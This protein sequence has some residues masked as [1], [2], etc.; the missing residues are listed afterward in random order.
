[1]GI[2]LGQ[3]AAMEIDSLLETVRAKVICNQ[4]GGESD[5]SVAWLK[6]HDSYDCPICGD[7]TD[8]T[9]QEWKAR[10]QAYIDA[11]TAFD[12]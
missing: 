2:F 4:C 12:E 8:L 7:S 3:T 1:M 5:Q 6:N 10:V 11:C 9:T